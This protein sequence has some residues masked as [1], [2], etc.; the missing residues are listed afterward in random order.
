MITSM[1]KPLACPCGSE[2]TYAI[3]CEPFHLGKAKA[4]TAEKLMRS[5][6]AAYAVGSID[7]I[8]KTNDPRTGENFDREAAETWSKKS[9][10]LGLTIMATKAG[11]AGDLSGEV[12]F[13][14]KFKMDGSETVHHEVSLFRFEPKE[15]QWYYTDGKE[16]REPI[17]R[18]EP[19]VGRN[20]PCPC[21]SGKKMKKCCA[22]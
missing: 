21:G 13:K 11:L 20:D 14:A 4:E 18:S 10:W 2:K 16:I 22:A 9:E 1:T 19:K 3:C 12:E 17:L 7:Y 8:G 6:Y 5:R 15:S